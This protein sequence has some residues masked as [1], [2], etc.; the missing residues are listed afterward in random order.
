MKELVFAPVPQKVSYTGGCLALNR[1]GHITVEDTAFLRTAVTAK[2]YVFDTLQV[3]VSHYP[4]SV[5]LV[6][7][8]DD[9]PSEGYTLTVTQQQIRIAASDAAGVFYGFMTLSQMVRQCGSSLPCVQIEDAP[10][11]PVRG[12]MLDI[13]NARIP[14]MEMFKE[15]V[16][17]MCSMKMNHFELKLDGAPFPFAD[18]PHMWKQCAVITGEEILELDAYCK[19]RFV[20][21]VP[22]QNTLGHMG[23]WL[24]SGHGLKKL[25]ES[26]DGF[27]SDFFQCWMDNPQT[28]SPIDPDSF[29]LVENITDSLLPYFS[30]DK[31]N[32]GCDET[33]E[34]GEGKSKEL[35]QKIGVGGVYTEYLLK[36]YGM[37]RERGKTMLFWT[38]ML[39]KFPEFVEKLP[40]EHI[41]AMNWGY[42]DG[43]PTAES[44][45]IYKKNNIPFCMCPGTAVWSTFLGNTTQM[46]DNIHDHVQK[47]CQYGAEGIV[48]TEWGAYRH[49]QAFTPNF[50]ALVLTAALS[51]QPEHNAELSLADALDVFVFEDQNRV[52]GRFVLDVGHYADYEPKH[53]ENTT[54]SFEIF[55]SDL[56]ETKQIQGVTHADFDRVRQYILSVYDSIDSTNMRCKDRDLYVKEYRLG[57]DLVLLA[58]DYGDYALYLRE[59]DAEKIARYAEKLQDERNRLLGIYPE[60]WLAKNR[61]GRLS[62]TLAFLEERPL[63]KG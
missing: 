39:N 46:L 19:A 33:F 5:I 2:A 15:L 17:H 3:T 25:A 44:C 7:N 60:L 23:G 13:A 41:L 40:R 14:T 37:C 55:R 50:P 42:Y 30:S 54:F 49:N 9:I 43:L 48:V 24:N 56:F 22:L 4:D 21:L 52:M 1:Y 16:D 31:Y 18:Y 45:E 61:F 34:L 32:V 27:Y 6:R 58:Q 12:F 59:G 57:M 36:L 38:D 29:A 63:V 26:P 20:E 28:L 35:A 51:W 11:F 47:A 8:A 10:Y 53:L 62:E